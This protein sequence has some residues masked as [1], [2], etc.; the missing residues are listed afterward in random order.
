MASTVDQI[1]GFRRWTAQLKA[2]E[3]NAAKIAGLNAKGSTTV[4]DAALIYD[5]IPAGSKMISGSVPDM[6]SVIQGYAPDTIK[7]ISGSVPDPTCLVQGHVASVTPMATGTLPAWQSDL[8]HGYVGNVRPVEDHFGKG[9]PPVTKKIPGDLTGLTSGFSLQDVQ[10]ASSALAPLGTV[11]DP[12]APDAMFQSATGLVEAVPGAEPAPVVPRHRERV[13]V[14]PKSLRYEP[15]EYEPVERKLQPP[16]VL[17]QEMSE[18]LAQSLTRHYRQETKG[19]LVAL[20]LDLELEHL[21]AIERRLRDGGRPDLLHA[22]L[23]ASLLLKG[24]ADRLYPPRDHEECWTCRFENKHK[25]GAPHVKNRLHAFADPV[26]RQ[27][28]TAEHKL[29]VA[30][31]DFVSRWSGEGHHVVLTPKENAE[32]FCALL[33]IMATVACAHRQSWTVLP[34]DRQKA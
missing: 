3:D 23:S 21:E 12:P 33:K 5:S 8:I 34:S 22:A 19:L 11:Q 20:G 32:A 29:F 17:P 4:A 30:E 24:V 31:L 2:V 1:E 26:L 27:Q 25:L 14:I 16:Q 10:C 15:H 18:T 9:M 6:A 28:S 7:M 13:T